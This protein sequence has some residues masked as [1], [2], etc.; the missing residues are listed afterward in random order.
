MDAIGGIKGAWKR[1]AREMRGKMEQD[2]DN[3]NV[4][5]R[6]KKTEWKVSTGL[7]LINSSS[8]LTRIRREVE[9]IPT[10][11]EINGG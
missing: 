10:D 7:E 5:K 1:A 2:V 11:W 8:T 9:Y 3:V 4:T 6:P